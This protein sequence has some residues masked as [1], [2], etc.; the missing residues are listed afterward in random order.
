M[1]GWEFLSSPI[2]NNEIGNKFEFINKLNANYD[3]NIDTSFIIPPNCKIIDTRKCE[4]G[5]ILL[6]NS[7]QFIVNRLST[8]IY[9]DNLIE[10]ETENCR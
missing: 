1:E 8:K 9:I 7:R 6:S 3:K 5:I 2:K 10:L 4:I